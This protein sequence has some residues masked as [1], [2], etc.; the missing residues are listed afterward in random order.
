M[1]LAS[2]LAALLL[3]AV[4]SPYFFAS[5]DILSFFWC[6]LPYPL[7]TAPGILVSVVCSHCLHAINNND[8]WLFNF[9]M[10]F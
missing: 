4:P 1:T 6:T 8:M 3:P 5:S 2:L 9:L 10:H 7:Y